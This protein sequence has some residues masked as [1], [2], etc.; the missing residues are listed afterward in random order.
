[1]IERLVAWGMVLLLLPG[2]IVLMCLFVPRPL[3]GL[4]ADRIGGAMVTFWN[5]IAM[6]AATIGVV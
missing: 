4:L 5:F 3:G 2:L 6:G 1:V